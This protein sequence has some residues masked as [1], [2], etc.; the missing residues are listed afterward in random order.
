MPASG[1]VTVV[2]SRYVGNTG[3]SSSAT[4]AGGCGTGGVDD[5]GGVSLEDSDEPPFEGVSDSGTSV[6]IR[7]YSWECTV[8]EA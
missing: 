8:S 2:S 5:S 4:G 7:L 6:T 1:M 3:G